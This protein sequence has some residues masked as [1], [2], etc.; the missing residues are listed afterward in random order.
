MVR[1]ELTVPGIYKDCIYGKHAARPYNATVEPEGAPNNYVHIN[2]WGP[3]SVMSMGGA[4]YMMVAVDGGSSHLSVFFLTRK[5]SNT[6]LMALTSY[7]TESERQ[8]GRRLWEVRVDAGREWVNKTWS[9][10]LGTHSIILKVMTP[11]AH[12][13]NGVAERANCTIL[14]G[15]RCV[16]AESSLPKELWAKAAAAQVHTR[17]LLPSS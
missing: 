9:T 16:L 13:Q 15:V 14:E 17:N 1:G 7:H 5:D 11:Y 6:T 4:T 3:A 8:T 2:L 10:Y 12:A